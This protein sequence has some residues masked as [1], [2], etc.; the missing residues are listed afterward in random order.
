MGQ[1]TRAEGMVRL[2]LGWNLLEKLSTMAG[3]RSTA[4]VL[5][6][7][8]PQVSSLEVGGTTDQVPEPSRLAFTR[9]RL[10][11]G[12]GNIFRASQPYN[13]RKVVRG[14]SK[15]IIV[16]IQYVQKNRV[17]IAVAKALPKTP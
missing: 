15:G 5:A 4:K 13:S 11:L 7:E 9:H 3:N 16:L 2:A 8:A 6:I 17:H 14:C 12:G 1:R 10:S